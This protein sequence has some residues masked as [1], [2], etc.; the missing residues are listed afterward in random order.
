MAITKAIVEAMKG[1]IE[2]TSALGKGS[3]LHIT[4]NLD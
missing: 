3:E 4:L 1:S 2:L